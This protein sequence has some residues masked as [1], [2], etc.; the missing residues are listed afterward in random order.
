MRKTRLQNRISGSMFTLPVCAVIT[1]LLWG[2]PL[3]E[4]EGIFLSRLSFTVPHFVA[5]V[6][7]ALI[8]YV[9]VE[10][11][12]VNMLIRVRSRLVSSV[13]LVSAAVVPLLH[14]YSHGLVAAVCLSVAYYQLFKTYQA[15]G[16]QLNAFHS[17]L[18]LSAGSLFV[19][20][21]LFFLPFFLWHQTVFLRSVTLR[22]LGA[23]FLGLA[24]P[25]VVV[26]GYAMVS[27][28]LS[29]LFRWAET[30]SLY[31]AVSSEAYQTLTLQQW[32]SWAV[33]S[34]WGWCITSPPVTVTASRPECS[35]MSSCASFLPSRRSWPSSPSTWMTGCPCSWLRV[36]PSRP[37][38]LP[39]R[40]PVSPMPCS[41]WPFAPSAPWACWA[42][43]KSICGSC[44]VESFSPHLKV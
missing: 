8:A 14:T 38:S 22:S 42:F 30:L 32:A 24:M 18:M 2:F 17:A 41:L 13:W 1:L 36:R 34:L 25:F 7:V 21:L 4:G 27:G 33:I 19:P 3:R 6:C 20:H 28:D 29:F 26:A 44:P 37:I 39:L 11:N 9:L 35:S 5:L 16:S 43:G 31:Y 23:V 10:M 40:V 12:N 15:P